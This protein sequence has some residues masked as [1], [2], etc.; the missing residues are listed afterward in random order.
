MS[1]RIF[2]F[3]TAYS[4]WHIGIFNPILITQSYHVPIQIF[5]IV[6]WTEYATLKLCPILNSDM[7]Y[8]TI[9]KLQHINSKN[10]R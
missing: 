9:T 2:K 4:A 1:L 7:N 3:L 8:K 10:R 5:K 6:T